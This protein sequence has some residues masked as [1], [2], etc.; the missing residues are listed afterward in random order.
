M[1]DLTAEL[2]YATDFWGRSERDVDNSKLNLTA[3]FVCTDDRE[4]PVSIGAW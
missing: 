3:Q 1:I 4:I 2:A